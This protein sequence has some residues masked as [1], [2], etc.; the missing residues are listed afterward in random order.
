MGVG[1]QDYLGVR[2]RVEDLSPGLNFLRSS[3]KIV[4][5]AVIGDGIAYSG[6]M[7]G[8]DPRLRIRQLG[9]PLAPFSA[10]SRNVA[11][12][13]LATQLKELAPGDLRAST[14]FFSKPRVRLSKTRTSATSSC[15]SRSV[16]NSWG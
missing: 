1:R 6:Q 3:Q 10:A 9:T 4:A 11:V 5:L 2:T 12:Q 15:V 7:H 13:H 8:L 14:R 16:I